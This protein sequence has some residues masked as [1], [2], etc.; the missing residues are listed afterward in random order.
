MEDCVLWGAIKQGVCNIVALP[1][2]L[3]KCL[4]TKEEL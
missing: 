3:K 1:I 4:N 2:T